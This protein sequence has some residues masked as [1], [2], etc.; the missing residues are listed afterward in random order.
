MCGCVFNEMLHRGVGSSF[1]YVFLVNLQVLRTSWD[2]FP[3]FGCS[4]FFIIRSLLLKSSLQWQSFSSHTRV[5]VYCVY[6]PLPCSH[7]AIC[8]L[9]S[10][11]LFYSSFCCQTAEQAPHVFTSALWKM[12]HHQSVDVGLLWFLTLRGH[13]D[14]MHQPYISPLPCWLSAGCY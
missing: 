3:Y 6:Y 14:H 7:N 1:F 9:F 5:C 11:L 10:F 12:P 8:L 13:K 2:N 4:S